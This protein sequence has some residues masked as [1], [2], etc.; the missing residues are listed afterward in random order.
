MPHVLAA[1]QVSVPSWLVP[2]CNPALLDST[3][4]ST[5]DFRPVRDRYYMILLITGALPGFRDHS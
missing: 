5:K 4:R 3:V 2:D 1:D